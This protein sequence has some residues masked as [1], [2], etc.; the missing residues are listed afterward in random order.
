[1]SYL[2]FNQNWED[3]GIYS[4]EISASDGIFSATHQEVYFNLDEI[5]S[6]GCQL[7]KFP[8]NINHKITYEDDS[9]S[10]Y[11]LIAF[12][13]INRSGDTAI[14]IKTDNRRDDHEHCSAHFFIPCE[15]SVINKLGRMLSAWTQKMDNELECV[16]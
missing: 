14:E 1:M 2:K 4:V 3:C 9:Q 15:A 7:Q 11:F 6:L 10:H 5:D 12:C 8:E 16:W 13:I